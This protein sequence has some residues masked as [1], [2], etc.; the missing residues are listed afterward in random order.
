MINARLTKKILQ[1][2]NERRQ[3]W[4]R[5]A[6]PEINHSMVK[7]HDKRAFQND[8]RMDVNK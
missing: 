8:I 4:N 1:K 2:S 7:V 5:T 3:H 6:C